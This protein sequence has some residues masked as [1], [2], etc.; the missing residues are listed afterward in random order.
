MDSTTANAQGSWFSRLLMAILFV[1]LGAIAFFNFFLADPRNQLSPSLLAL[2]GLLVVVALA[3]TF[4]SFSV[5]ALLTVSR[6]LKKK[7]EENGTLRTENADL[8]GHL[9]QLSTSISQRQS[10]TNIIGLPSDLAHAY[11]VQQAPPEE[12]QE[13]RVEEEPPQRAPRLTFKSSFRAR[14]KLED[15]AIGKYMG[16]NG[17]QHLPVIRDAKLIPPGSAAD[18]VSDYTPVFDGYISAPDAEAFVEVR[19]RQAFAVAF[20]DRLYA[21]L[22]RIHYYRAAKGTPAYLALVLVTTPGGE[23]RD[24]GYQRLLRDFQPAI[25]NGLLRVIDIAMSKEDVAAFESEGE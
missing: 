14:Q 24:G 4:D 8:R 17:W 13:A 12:A 7:S 9:V 20:R 22:S 18:P 25:G 10:S 23:E 5:G 19:L 1:F 15:A 2:L 6:E 16:A 11:S 21:M 3:D